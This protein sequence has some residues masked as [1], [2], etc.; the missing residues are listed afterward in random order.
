LALRLLDGAV[1]HFGNPDR[2]DCLIIYGETWRAAA[3]A[4]LVTLGLRK[5]A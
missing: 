4:G 2:F 3:S 1:I 5:P